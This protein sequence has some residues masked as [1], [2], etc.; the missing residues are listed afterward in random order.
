MLKALNGAII[1]FGEVARN[2]HWPAYAVNPD[3]KIVA[4]V[5]R[6]AERREL[7]ARLS[8]GVATFA[9]FDEVPASMPI[10]FVDICTPPAL[11]PQP[12]LK[13]LARGCHVLCEKPFL[14]DSAVLEIVRGRAAEA[15]VAVM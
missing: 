3:M 4:V 8:P 5:D 2:G 12:M 6:T 15:G 14:L 13:A 7:A 10:D 1:G 11:H 9:T